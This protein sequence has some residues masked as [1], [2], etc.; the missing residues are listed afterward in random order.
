MEKESRISKIIS[1]WKM[2]LIVFLATMLSEK[3][4]IIKIPVGSG[5]IMFLPL[6]YCMIICLIL[7]LIKSFTFI[8]SKVDCDV[9]DN[10]VVI[11]I[12]VFCAKIGVN[13]GAAIESVISAGPAL[14][15]QEL[16]NLGTIL[17][18]LP[19]ALLLGF[20]REAVGMTHSIGREPNIAFIADKCGMNSPEGRGIMITYVVGT[21]FGTIFLG[22]VA[23][24]LAT[25]T[26]LHPL[27]LAMAC[28]VG[29][30]SMMAASVAPLMEAFPNIA[31]EISAYAGISNTLSTA[32]GIFVTI[33]IA[34]PLCNF[35]YKKLEP[36][37]GRTTSAT[38]IDEDSD[39]EA[40]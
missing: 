5:S 34:Y 40:K 12:A 19:I 13:S 9:A 27:S 35:L 30:G 24:L 14:I 23:S 29:S 22:A 38:I 4:G 7:A 31:T 1:C 33:F 10:I 11:G 20:K 32:D 6:L 17:F 8:G 39:K 16:G 37:I 15:L 28:G 2:V 3:F 26:P 36:I 21:L 18:A 25:G